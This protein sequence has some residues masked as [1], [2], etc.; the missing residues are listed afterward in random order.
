MNWVAQ[1]ELTVDE[2]MR[3]LTLTAAQ[4]STLLERLENVPGKDWQR[5]AIVSVP[6]GKT[7][8]YTATYYGDW[9]AA[10]ER[11]HLDQIEQT[12]TVVTHRRP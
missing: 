8:H 5:T 9:L 7:F 2:I 6:P 4:R 1:S 10:H 11:V 3:I 12:A